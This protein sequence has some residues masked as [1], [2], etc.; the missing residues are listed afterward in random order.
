[1]ESNLRYIVTLM[2]LGFA[3]LFIYVNVLPSCDEFEVFSKEYSRLSTTAEREA[4][5]TEVKDT[6]VSWSGRVLMTDRMRG[7]V[8]VSTHRIWMEPAFQAVLED[9]TSLKYLEKGDHITVT[10]YI[11]NV[12]EGIWLL[13]N[14]TI[15]E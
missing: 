15:Q 3:L 13:R 11:S 14:A 1:M 9:A 6:E 10:G 4:Y 5:F 8:F 12:S 2:V 7:R